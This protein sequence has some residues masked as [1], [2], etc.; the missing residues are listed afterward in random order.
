MSIGRRHLVGSLYLV[1]AAIAGL[2]SMHGLDG[3]VASF[4]EP[5]HS[6]HGPTGDTSGYETLGICVFVAA[7]AGLGIAAV[8]LPRRA[9]TTTRYGRTDG[10]YFLRARP[11][12][13]GVS[14]LVH[15][16]VLRL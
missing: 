16:C 7:I 2:L 12:V 13:S 9:A 6:S 4:V 8:G 5:S 3:V 1:T 11:S 14:R 10:R 15:L